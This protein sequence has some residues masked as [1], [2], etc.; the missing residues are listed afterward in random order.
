MAVSLTKKV[1]SPKKPDTKE[2]VDKLKAAFSHLNPS[3]LVTQG[4]SAFREYE[5]ALEQVQS[6]LGATG[7]QMTII[8]EA[9]RVLGDTTKYTSTDIVGAFVSASE[10]GIGF[11]DS[12][13][14][15]PSI[16]NMAAVDGMDFATSAQYMEQFMSGLNISASETESLIDKMAQTTKISGTDMTSLGDALITSGESLTKFK[17]GMSDAN[18]MLGTLAQ[19]GIEGSGAGAL[20][21]DMLENVYSSSGKSADAL[22]TLGIATTNADGS[23][24][25][26]TTIMGELDSTMQGG[27]LDKYK[28]TLST[29]FNIEDDG[30]LTSMIENM[31]SIGESKAQIEASDG[32]A[33][34]M[35]GEDAGASIDQSLIDI[36]ASLAPIIDYLNEIKEIAIAPYIEAL[37]TFAGMFWAI[38]SNLLIPL[39]WISSLFSIL[40]PLIYGL[41]GALLAYMAIQKAQVIFTNIKKIPTLLKEMATKVL[42]LGPIGLIIM[43]VSA[44]VG[45]LAW[46]VKKFDC[47]RVKVIEVLNFFIRQINKILKWIGKEINELSDDAFKGKNYNDVKNKNEDPMKEIYEKYGKDGEKN[48][49]PEPPLEVSTPPTGGFKVD[50]VGEIE[51]KDSMGDEEIKILRDLATQDAINKYSTLAPNIKI[52]FGE[53]KETADVEVVAKRLEQILVEQIAISSDLAY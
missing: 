35:A 45:V 19:S 31:S 11:K 9:S 4:V 43:A 13:D 36:G 53:V 32:V 29:L 3:V 28:E 24:K 34:E 38:I 49:I 37:A 27:S 48:K 16:L 33:S 39:G 17:V 15:M 6:S 18:A 23:F 42:T 5:E 14:A 2:L 21:G 40:T 12:V 10:A 1:D 22:R 7:K 50:S 41:V 26:I 25:D 46:A 30:T 51:N 52:E 47:V 44:I 20:L 8:D